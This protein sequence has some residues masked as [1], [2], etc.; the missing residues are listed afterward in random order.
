MVTICTASLTFNNSTFCPTQLYLCVLCGSENKQPLFPYTTL[1]D[2]SIIDTECLLH[3]T[4]CLKL[5]IQIHIT[6]LHGSGNSCRP[7]IPKASVPSIVSPRVIYVGQFDT[8]T[9]FSPGTCISPC[10]YH[11]T[12]TRTPIFLCT[13]L[14]PGQTCGSSEPTAEQCCHVDRTALDRSSS[15]WL[16]VKL[17]GCLS[18]QAGHH[19]RHA[20]NVMP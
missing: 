20:I 10:Q 7:L 6:S 4:D 19:W 9:G 11:S 17:F 13:L 5:T 3:G 16:V 1:T 14:L 15:L 12:N 18:L 2:F 8:R